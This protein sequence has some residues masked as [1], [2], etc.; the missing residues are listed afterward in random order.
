MWQQKF[1]VRWKLLISV[2]LSLY[3][4][5][6]AHVPSPKSNTR[7]VLRIDS[8]ALTIPVKPVVVQAQPAPLRVK[9]K[10]VRN[11]LKAK[12]AKSR[13][14]SSSWNLGK[15]RKGS[16]TVMVSLADQRAYVYRNGIRIGHTKVSTGKRGHETPTGSFKIL[17]KR[18][19]HKSNLYEDGDMPYMQRLTWD[20]IA[21]HAGRVPNRPASHGCIRMPHSFARKLYSITGIGSRVVIADYHSGKDK[22]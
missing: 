22:I 6:C 16:V 1:G 8:S 4:L 17:Q 15:A 5:G 9:V 3:L 21:L 2:L 10:P 18:K 7:P 12:P 20:G 14:S 19:K 11:H 13:A